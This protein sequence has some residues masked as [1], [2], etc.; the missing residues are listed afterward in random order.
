MMLSLSLLV[1]MDICRSTSSK[2]FYPV[3]PPVITAAKKDPI[4]GASI[5]I[6]GNHT[7]HTNI[8]PVNSLLVA[9]GERRGLVLRQLRKLLR[10]PLP[11]K[12]TMLPLILI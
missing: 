7:S 4:F 11:S 6:T 12:Q 8:S 5:N 2:V 3:T 9:V 1:S 10:K